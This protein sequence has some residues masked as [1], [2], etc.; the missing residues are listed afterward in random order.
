MVAVT[1]NEK[2]L[3]EIVRNEV[4]NNV[5]VESEEEGGS[6]KS[7]SNFSAASCEVIS[8]NDIITSNDKLEEEE[9]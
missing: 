8:M 4:M 3:E 1:L 2:L 7:G 9:E 5:Q 6:R